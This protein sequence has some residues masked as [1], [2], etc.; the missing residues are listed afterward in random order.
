MKS[1]EEIF[2]QAIKDINFELTVANG[3]L[4]EAEAEFEKAKRTMHH[5]ENL[6]ALNLDRK[7][8]LE[9]LLTNLKQLK[10]NNV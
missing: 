1:N 7:N 2:D 8:R 6:V 5:K 3:D 4:I 9:Q 10:T